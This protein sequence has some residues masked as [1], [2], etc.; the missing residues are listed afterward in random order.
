MLRAIASTYWTGRPTGST[1][2]RP[3]T[4][5]SEN[6]TPYNTQQFTGSASDI[7]TVIPRPFVSALRTILASSAQRDTG[8]GRD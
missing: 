4:P 3:V 6:I 7:R 5:L 8:H 2:K 1:H